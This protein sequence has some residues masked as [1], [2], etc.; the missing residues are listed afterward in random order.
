MLHVIAAEDLTVDAM[1]TVRIRVSEVWYCS[2][3]KCS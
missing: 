3:H 2:V 1:L